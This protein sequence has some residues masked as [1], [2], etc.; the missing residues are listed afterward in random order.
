M[1]DIIERMETV[2]FVMFVYPPDKCW[3][4]YIQNLNIYASS[5]QNFF[6]ICRYYSHPGFNN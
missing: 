4:N 6:I 3:T 2:N 5:L 1:E